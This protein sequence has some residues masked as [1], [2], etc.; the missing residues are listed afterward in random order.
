MGYSDTQVDAWSPDDDALS[1]FEGAIRGEQFVLLL[2]TVDGD[3]AGY[4]VLNVDATRID[5]VFVDP[6]YTGGDLGRRWSANSRPVHGCS[7]SPT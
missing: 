3:P 6:G 5:A 4:G 7:V 1:T 2:V